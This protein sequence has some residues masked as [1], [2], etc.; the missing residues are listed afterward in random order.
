MR[1]IGITGP[2]GAGK[3]FLS[4]ALS[5]K[6]VPC[7]DADSVYHTLL[8]PPSPCLDALRAAFGDSVFLPDGSL[9]RKAL[10]NIVFN[11]SEKL[12]LLNSTVLELVL[13][14]IREII[15]EL[16]QAGHSAVAVDA[17]TLI[18]SGFDKECDTV[19]SVLAPHSLRI[20]RIMSRDGITR[21]AAELR[22]KAQKDDSFYVNASDHVITNDGD[23][24]Q[25]ER[26]VAELLESII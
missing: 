2:S 7:I 20:E 15:A 23:G 13:V 16:A 8:I 22:V 12:K 9:D 17:P 24:A 18:E 1:I 4:M 19:I 5:S 11:D 26:R 3:S 25:L 21:E 14:R 6:G 10:G